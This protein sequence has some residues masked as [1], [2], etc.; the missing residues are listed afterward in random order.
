MNRLRLA[1]ALL[2]AVALAACGEK[3]GPQTITGTVPGAAV[4]FNNFAVGSPS[5]NFYANDMKVTGVKETATN[6]ES[7]S[8]TSYGSAAA[9][10][11]YAGLTPGSYTL[12][13]RLADTLSRDVSIAS[14]PMTL[15]DGKY[16]SFYLS[17][18][19]NATTKQAD[20][21]ILEDAFPAQAYD[22]AYVRFV[23]AIS[24]TNPLTLYAKSTVAGSTETAVGGPTAY[25]AGTAFVPLPPGVYD[26]AARYTGVTTNAIAQ[27]AVSFSA[28]RVYTVNARGDITITS[29]TAST[30]PILT[31]VTNR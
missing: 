12:S 31:T 20:S 16:Y 22:V 23:N 26:L 4:Q 24:N 18:F 7:T 15:V 1:A 14:M 30:R 9:T 3:H 21:F 10:G 25:K 17:G 2:G 6:V 13:G 8:G 11:T 5:V 29:T 28:G 27:T 19:Y